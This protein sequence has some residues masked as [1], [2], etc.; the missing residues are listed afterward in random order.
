MT[1]QVV[2]AGGRPWCL[3]VQSMKT[4]RGARLR[5]LVQTNLGLAQVSCFLAGGRWDLPRPGLSFPNYKA[6]LTRA[7]QGERTV[8]EP[9]WLAG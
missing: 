1:R 6:G 8:K 7:F 2:T 9:A 4:R 3:L 5:F